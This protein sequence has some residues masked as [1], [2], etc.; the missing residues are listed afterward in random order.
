MLNSITNTQL[1]TE[2]RGHKTSRVYA[3]VRL[4]VSASSVGVMG[5]QAKWKAWCEGGCAPGVMLEAMVEEA[6]VEEELLLDRPR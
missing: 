5:P 2:R 1:H 4:A 6:A 3:P